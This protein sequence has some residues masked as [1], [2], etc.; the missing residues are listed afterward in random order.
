L[1]PVTTRAK[2]LSEKAVTADK[3]TAIKNERDT[4]FLKR[5]RTQLK[6]L[7][8]PAKIDTETD[9][10]PGWIELSKQEIDEFVPGD[11]SAVKKIK[12]FATNKLNA[13]GIFGIFYFAQFEQDP[14]DRDDV[15][16]EVMLA[17]YD[18]NGGMADNVTLAIDDYGSGSSKINSLKDIIYMY[19]SEMEDIRL[20]KRTYSVENFKFKMNA[21]ETIDFKGNQE[22]ADAHTAYIENILK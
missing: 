4:L 18:Q 7:V 6:D 1:F 15:R 17:I 16:N 3:R 11:Y 19:S 14:G 20:I 22:G 12:V 21:E 2:N 13:E 8:I 9:L 10:Q 5:L